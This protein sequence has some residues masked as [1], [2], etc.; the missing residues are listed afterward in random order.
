MPKVS[1]AHGVSSDDYLFGAL[2]SRIK[3]RVP[4]FEIQYKNKSVVSKILGFLAFFNRDYMTKYTTTFGDLVKYPSVKFVNDN[5]WRAFKVLAHEYVHILDNQV[6][7]LLFK[8]LYSAPQWL[9]L[10]SSLALLSIWFSNWWLLALIGLIFLGPWPSPRSH[11]EMRGY[12][13]NIAINMWRYGDIQESTKEWL[14][15]KFTGWPYYR[16][17]W[18]KKT[19]REWIAETERL[20]RNIDQI[21]PDETIF[22]TSVAFQDV[23]ELLTDIEFDEAPE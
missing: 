11:L 7:P 19:V 1:W 20:V 23:Y 13:M 2:C 6:H 9:V 22:D 4:G 14:V 12:A 16:M 17:A 10:L 5:K 21:R 15:E 18:S 8:I 3:G